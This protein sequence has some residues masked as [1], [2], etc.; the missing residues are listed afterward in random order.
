MIFTVLGDISAIKF[1]KRH[2]TAHHAGRLSIYF[3]DTVA[4]DFT[5]RE[6]KNALYYSNLMNDLKHLDDLEIVADVST[7]EEGLMACI[8]GVNYVSS[9]LV[10][11]TSSTSHVKLPDLNIIKQFNERLPIPF[12]AEGGYSSEEDIKM[13]LEY[14]AYGIVIGTAITR[15]HII[16]KGYAGLFNQYY[17]HG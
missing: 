2:S 6:S 4:I 8:C 13:A 10:G 9:T 1:K 17:N 11:Y 7:I 16:T 15:P 14:N 12:F 3:R 5:L